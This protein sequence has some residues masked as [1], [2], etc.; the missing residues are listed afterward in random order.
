MA[1]SM[2]LTWAA[3][4]PFC[5][6]NTRAEPRGPVSGVSTSDK[7]TILTLFEK[8][9]VSPAS[10]RARD[11]RPSAPG[12]MGRPSRSRSRAP[13][14]WAMPAPASEEALPPMPTKIV[15]APASAAARMSSPVPR[16]EAP[17]ASRP[18]PSRAKPEAR[19]IST[20]AVFRSKR[21][22]AAIRR[23]PRGPWTRTRR[24]FPPRAQSRA[25]MSP[26]PPSETGPEA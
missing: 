1:S 11:L 12:P 8:A 21:A 14:A 13:R 2:I 16:V 9:A 17:I 23:S 10:I 6:P 22:K 7:A 26:S 5:G 24:T 18:P 4:A 15:R 20:T 25:S 19:A 3:V